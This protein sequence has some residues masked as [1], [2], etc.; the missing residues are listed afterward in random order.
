MHRLDE[1]LSGHVALQTSEFLG[2]DDHHFVAP[3]H[4]DVLRPFAPD[5]ANK[6]AETRLGVLQK[7][8]APA[9][10]RGRALVLLG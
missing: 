8:I 4:G 2:G 10:F 9:A 1:L 6:F 3:M 5:L 7:P